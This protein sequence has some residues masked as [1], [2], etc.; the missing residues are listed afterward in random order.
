[1][2]YFN[3]QWLEEI[4]LPDGS[5]ATCKADIERYMKAN[6][7]ALAQDYSPQYMKNVRARNEKT[8]KD[9]IF[10]EFIFNYKRKIWNE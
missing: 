10:A 5:I 7:A 4:E 1:M 3:R 6:D 2:A 9:E 8:R